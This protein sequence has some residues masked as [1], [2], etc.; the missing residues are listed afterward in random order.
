GWSMVGCLLLCCTL[1]F[2]F[3]LAC[4]LLFF[5]F[6]SSRRRHTRFDC[7]WSS[8]VCSSDLG[9][10]P[11]QGAP[12]R[13]RSPGVRPLTLVRIEWLCV[14]SARLPADGYLSFNTG[15][16]LPVRRLSRGS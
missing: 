6:F 15:A 4:C 5:F 10:R 7:D 9:L 1:L 16:S 13:G 12:G 2:I 8:D 11:L 3:F 14:G